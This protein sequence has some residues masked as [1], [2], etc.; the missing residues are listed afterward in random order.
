MCVVRFHTN[1]HGWAGWAE[2][3][4]RSTLNVLYHLT[5]ITFTSSVVAPGIVIILPEFTHMSRILLKHDDKV[6]PPV[7]TAHRSFL[8]WS[9]NRLTTRYSF[10]WLIIC[11]FHEKSPIVRDIRDSPSHAFVSGGHRVLLGCLECCS[12]VAVVVVVVLY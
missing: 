6:L 11:R 9:R 8:R 7:Q 10:F 2:G 4:L 3:I 5:P 12:R 1:P